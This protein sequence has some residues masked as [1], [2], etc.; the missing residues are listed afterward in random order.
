MAQ[1]PRPDADVTTTNWGTTPL[2]SK[3]DEVTPSDTDYI[4]AVANAVA[5]AECSLSDPSG[6]PLVDTGHIVRARL[7]AEKTNKAAVIT[8]SLIQGTTSIRAVAYDAEVDLTT[9]FAEYSFT[10]SE[11]EAANIDNYNDLRLRFAQTT[12]TAGNFL[13]VS[14][15][16]LE[17]PDA[18]PTVH[19]D[20]G[21]DTVDLSDSATTVH[22]A[23][24][25]ASDTFEMTDVGVGVDPNALEFDE[26]FETDPGYDET[27]SDG[28]IETGTGVIDEDYPT[29]SVTG[30][31][32]WWDDLCLRLVGDDAGSARVRHVLTG[33]SHPIGYFRLEFILKS[34]Q[35]SGA[36]DMVFAEGHY[37]SPDNFFKFMIGDN[38][39]TPELG[40]RLEHD[41]LPNDTWQDIA[42]D[43]M[44]RIE[45]YWDVTNDLWSYKVDGDVKASGALTGGAE[46]RSGWYRIAIGDDGGETDADYEMFID[47]VALS[48]VDWVGG[49]AGNPTGVG[50]D[51]TDL[52]DSATTVLDATESSSETADLSDS[53][54]GTWT[55]ERTGS[56]AADLS[57]SAVAGL[58]SAETGTEQADLS[59]SAAAAATKPESVSET[60]D[61]SEATSTTLKT[62]P[63]ASEATDLSD[64]G[65]GV[66]QA[67]ESV[68]E[69]VDLSDSAVSVTL[70]PVT[71]SETAELSDS[72][73]TV[74]KA[75]ES[76][77]ETVD[78]SDLGTYPDDQVYSNCKIIFGG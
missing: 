78:F 49:P 11:A 25:S 40:A 60:A 63:T 6:T 67:L 77:S 65:A 10:L 21:A 20:D 51:I 44:Y 34:H 37:E 50:A 71:G 3:I 45:L 46:N 48:T 12:A 23:G 74:L 9:S 16:E 8:V 29:S 24:M 69:A 68:A 36:G 75:V 43:T 42:Y 2:W 47:N 53:A 64:T 22:I 30:A 59:D 19:E 13:E 31:P 73:T 72:A 35:L 56:E 70:I 17:I 62:V 26:K 14:W 76:V 27:W 55:G 4:T 57:D 18:G 39:G 38:S 66:L 15:A 28:E 7:R 41:D 52:S 61:L 32:A 1:F 54:V 58:L 5:T 33:G